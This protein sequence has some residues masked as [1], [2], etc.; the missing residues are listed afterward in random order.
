MTNGE[1]YTKDCQRSSII[2]RLCKNTQVHRLDYIT[3]LC[4][5]LITTPT[6]GSLFLPDC[7]SKYSNIV[8]STPG[9]G[10]TN[11]NNKNDKNDNN[12]VMY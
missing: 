5:Y 12:S 2:M 8:S 7:D 1:I 6:I 9:A 3:P 11:D 4:S 10:S